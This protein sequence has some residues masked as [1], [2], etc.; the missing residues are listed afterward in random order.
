MTPTLATIQLVIDAEA[1]PVPFLMTD[2]H[3]T[4]MDLATKAA[5]HRKVLARISN[6][7]AAIFRV[8]RGGSPL[9]FDTEYDADET[10]R[11]QL[12]VLDGYPQVTVA[13]RPA[14]APAFTPPSPKRRRDER[15]T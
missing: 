9:E 5:K 14:E 1:A 13:A 12:A 6:I 3:M 4:L 8:W 7:H 2:I 11:L 10:E 15:E